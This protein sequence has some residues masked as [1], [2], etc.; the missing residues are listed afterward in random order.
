MLIFVIIR[1]YSHSARNDFLTFNVP[2]APPPY[3]AMPSS[4]QV[5]GL[6]ISARISLKKK[7]G[8]PK[9]QMLN[10]IW[11]MGICIAIR[12]A[13]ILLFTI[14]FF[15]RNINGKVKMKH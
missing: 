13:F 11:V 1:E 3:A 12:R 9:I 8:Y 5:A 14:F 6:E 4:R 10:I 7:N 2:G 15:L